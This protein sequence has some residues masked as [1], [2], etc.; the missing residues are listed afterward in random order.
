MVEVDELLKIRKKI[1]KMLEKYPD[2]ACFII[3]KDITVGMLMERI[4]G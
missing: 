2:V 1:G 3:K 4:Y